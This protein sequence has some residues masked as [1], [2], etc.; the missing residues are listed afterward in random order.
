MKSAVVLLTVLSIGGVQAAQLGDV[1]LP[2]ENALPTSATCVTAGCF[3]DYIFADET[4]TII[5][6]SFSLTNLTKFFDAVSVNMEDDDVLALDWDAP[7]S[8]LTIFQA[9]WGTAEL[10]GGGFP[11]AINDVSISF[12]GGTTWYGVP[13]GDFVADT[14][15]T[16]KIVNVSD[17]GRFE[18]AWY[19][20]WHATVDLATITGGTVT[21]TLQVHVAGDD[22]SGCGAPQPDNCALDL[23]GVAN[24]GV[25]GSPTAEDDFYETAADDNLSVDDP[26]VL[27]NDSDPDGDPLTA[28]LVDDPVSGGVAN[29]FADGS[30]E[31]EPPDGYLGTDSFTYQAYDG[32]QFSNVATV[33]VAVTGTPQFATFL[34]ETAFLDALA[35]QGFEA[36][37]ES[38]EDDDVWG[39][40]RSSIPGGSHTA[41]AISSMGI[42]WTGNN[43]TSEVTTSNGPSRTGQWGFYELPHGSY[44]TGVDCHLPG[45]CTDGFIATSSP[46]LFGVGAWINGI[47]GLQDRGHPGRQPDCRLRGRF[48]CRQPSQVLRRDRSER[49]SFLRGA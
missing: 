39:S 6:H 24:T 30:F 32:S 38:F 26:G 25:S 40:V 16:A 3:G 45:N 33:S 35:A 49:I 5:G 7:L 28:V 17:G 44:A 48:R 34:D 20:A 12:D 47:L 10:A 11:G 2:D 23:I 42:E 21:S 13:A 41:P 9:A 19:A 36:T 22:N 15:A 46:T 14:V 27:E 29:L 18:G 1:L 4:L 31:Y 8:E 37:V 43:D